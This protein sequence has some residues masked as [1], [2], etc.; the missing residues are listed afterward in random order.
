MDREALKEAMKTSISEVLET[1]FF[2]PLEVSETE[3]DGPL[4]RI[5]PEKLTSARLQFQGRFQGEAMFLVPYTLATSLTA[6]FM[7]QEPGK[8]GPDDVQGTLK[9][10]L[11][12]ICGKALSL[13]DPKESFNLGIPE[14]IDS[15]K[16]LGGFCSKEENDITLVF[17]AIE[18]QLAVRMAF[19]R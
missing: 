13:F 11:N 19:H 10:L 15:G 2:L 4:F 16:A 6:D 1:M 14:M 8:I 17:N 7:G 3:T 5:P 9:E 12:M 18:N